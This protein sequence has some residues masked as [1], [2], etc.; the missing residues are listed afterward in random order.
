MTRTLN[1]DRYET[2]RVA[3][4]GGRVDHIVRADR[5]ATKRV[6]AVCGKRGRRADQPTGR[7]CTACTRQPWVTDQRTLRPANEETPTVAQSGPLDLADIRPQLAEMRDAVAA[8]VQVFLDNCPEGFDAA[9]VADAIVDVCSD[10]MLDLYRARA[11]RDEYRDL[12]TR[13]GYLNDPN[14]GVCFA[15]TGAPISQED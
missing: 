1:R 11:E 5:I 7:T 14:E 9:T 12:L 2:D 15:G 8:T 13:E 10:E 3:I 4:V 6:V